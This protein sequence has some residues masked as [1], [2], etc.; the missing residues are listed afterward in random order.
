MRRVLVLL[1]CV[2]IVALIVGGFVLVRDFNRTFPQLRPGIYAGTLVSSNKTESI[3]WMVESTVGS[4]D[5]FVSVGLPG[6]QA[7]RGV[8]VEP[9][10]KTRLPLIVSGNE[11]RFRIIGREDDNSTYEGDY[12]DPIT[13]ERGTWRLKRY[14]I[15]SLDKAVRDDLV[16]WVTTW[17][18]LRSVET[19]IEEVKNSYDTDEGRIEKLHRYAVEGDS[20]QKAANSRLS[21]TASS[22]EDVKKQNVRQKG[23]LDELLRNIDISKRVSHEGRLVELSRETIAREGRWIE[24]ALHIAAPDASGN[25]D[26]LYERALRVKALQDQIADERGLIRNITEGS[27]SQRPDRER[28]SEEAFYNELQ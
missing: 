18:A 12:S 9:S 7:Q 19:K 25:F 21:S 26:A 3:P 28:E 22:L 27:Q 13:S 15:S 6:M 11:R 24:Q 23:E 8:V 14:E 4:P 5:I 16:A 17:Q 10:S 1:F 2:G 20:L